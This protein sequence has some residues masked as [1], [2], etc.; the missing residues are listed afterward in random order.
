MQ[1]GDFEGSVLYRAENRRILC[2]QWFAGFSVRSRVSIIKRAF[3][4][5]IEGREGGF[6]VDEG[7]PAGELAIHCASSG[8]WSCWHEKVKFIT[9]A[10]EEVA[11][12]I[13]SAG[14]SVLR[15]LVFR[16]ARAPFLFF[17]PLFRCFCSPATT[18]LPRPTLPESAWPCVSGCRPWP[19]TEIASPPFSSRALSLAA[20]CCP[21][22]P[23]Q[24]L[25]PPTCVCVD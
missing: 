13:G 14:D 12:K 25:S 23:T 2:F 5:K 8:G 20:Q 4:I 16:S 9:S 1:C 24:T 21:A 6:G 11:E 18:P 19:P 15:V 3:C 7:I 10:A 22:W 17:R